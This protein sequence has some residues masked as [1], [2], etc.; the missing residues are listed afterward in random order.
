MM[1]ILFFAVSFLAAMGGCGG[2][3]GGSVDVSPPD[4][5]AGGMTIT[6]PKVTVDGN[7]ANI[8]G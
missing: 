7:I 4:G 5:S 3:D 1:W 2:N 8:T 6:G